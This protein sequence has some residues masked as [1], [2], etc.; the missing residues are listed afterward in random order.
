MA[1]AHTAPT[2]ETAGSRHGRPTDRSRWLALIV[3]SLA[4]LMDVLDGTII[5]I[6]LP[7]AQAD[8]G[9]ASESRA[10]I[11]TGYALAYGSLLLFMGRLSDRFGR[12]RLFLVGLIGFAVAS[13]VGG[14]AG[15]FEML[16][17][18]RIAQGVFAATLAPAALSLVSVTFDRDKKERARAF[19]VFGAVSGMGG[20]IGLILGGVLTGVVSWRWCLYINVAIA[21]VALVGGLLFVRDE[22]RRDRGAALDVPGAALVVAGLFGMVYGLSNAADHG[23]SDLWTWLPVGAAVVLIGLFVLRQYRVANP[24][25]PLRVVVDRN[26]GAALM[27]IGAAGVGSF[28]AFLFLTYYL[29]R[30]LDFTPLQSGFGFVPM[31]ATLV[32]GAA[33][34]GS[35]LLPRFGPRPLVPLGLVLAAVA[36]VLLT[37][38]GSGDD[39]ASHVLPSVLILGLGFGFVF[40]SAQN[41]AT[42]GLPAQDNGVASAMVSTAQQVG[43]SIGLAVF[44]SIAAAAG[45][46]Y[47]ESHTAGTNRAQLQAVA[48]L[49]GDHIVFWVA[50]GVFLAAAVLTAVMFRSGPIADTDTEE[51]ETM[52]LDIES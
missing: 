38:I 36:V 42:S 3:L 52:Q 13:A 20:V 4:Q 37:R 28:A 25:L 41:V 11:V 50:A 22:V 8:L 2:A 15:S 34:S 43:G 47:V 32:L 24:L 46:A 12:K 14:A 19:S 1:S 16:L 18:A 31:V 51:D 30:D 10:W 26:R 6:A 23:W 45:T 44:T 40:G 17:I 35:V 9:F 39:Y 27:S 29:Q 49:Y 48:T 5:N 21:A 7:T 33:V